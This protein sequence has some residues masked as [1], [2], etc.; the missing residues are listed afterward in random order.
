MAQFL[1]QGLHNHS[2]LSQGAAMIAQGKDHLHIKSGQGAGGSGQD[3]AALLSPDAMT[4]VRFLCVNDLPQ[5]EVLVPQ[6]RALIL[7]AI[8]G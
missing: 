7:S 2:C 4:G 8:G 1:P 5:L 6:V 3:V